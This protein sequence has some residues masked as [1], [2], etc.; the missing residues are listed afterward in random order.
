MLNGNIDPDGERLSLQRVEP[1]EGD[2]PMRDNSGKGEAASQTR[3]PTLD[4][5]SGGTGDRG[6]DFSEGAGFNLGRSEEPGAKHSPSDRGRGETA[7][8]QNG[9]PIDISQA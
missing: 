7:D 3:D 8:A 4:E 9:A 6:G 5:N 1:R 2:D